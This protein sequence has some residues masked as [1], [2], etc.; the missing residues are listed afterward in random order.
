MARTVIT[1]CEGTFAGALYSP[2]AEILPEAG[3]IDQT[4]A[5]F[6]VPETVAENCAVAPA[7]ISAIGGSTTTES[8]DGFEIAM[9][10]V[11]VTPAPVAVT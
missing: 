5:L 8:A 3:L 6:V 4:T 7:A 1:S 10:A 2:V 11:F 9:A